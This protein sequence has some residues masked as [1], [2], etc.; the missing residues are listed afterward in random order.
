[1][2]L[3]ALGYELLDGTMSVRENE[4]TPI[5]REIEPVT[6][7]RPPD[8]LLTVVLIAF[9]ETP[10]CTLPI[11]PT[12]KLVSVPLPA[13]DTTWLFGVAPIA[14]GAVKRTSAPEID[15]VTWYPGGIV[16]AQ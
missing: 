7:S 9:E 11:A 10:S 4:P 1:M 6:A 13:R 14:T 2:R 3:P 12:T 8:M 15:A 16:W 5:R